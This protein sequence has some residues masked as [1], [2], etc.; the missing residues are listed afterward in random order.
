MAEN[1]MFKKRKKRLPHSIKAAPYCCYLAAVDD[2]KKNNIQD[3]STK[4][5]LFLFGLIME[6]NL[7]GRY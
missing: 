5:V 2:Q 7:T 6:M 4:F 3:A 1:D